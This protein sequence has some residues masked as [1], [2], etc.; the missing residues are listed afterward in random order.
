MSKQTIHKP[1]PKPCVN[2]TPNDRERAP[3]RTREETASYRGYSKQP[4]V[5]RESWNVPYVAFDFA[6]VSSVGA[7]GVEDF[8]GEMRDV[9]LGDRG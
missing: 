5:L 9:D 3:P 2:P 4:Y 7:E 1:V 8:A 6:S